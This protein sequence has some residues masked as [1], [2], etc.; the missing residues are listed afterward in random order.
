MLLA[1][2]FAFGYTRY[3]AM[4]QSPDKLVSR[5]TVS[6][7]KA[8]VETPRELGETGFLAVRLTSKAEGEIRLRLKG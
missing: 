3:L 8:A 5:V 2:G 4:V 6:G 1:A 7:G